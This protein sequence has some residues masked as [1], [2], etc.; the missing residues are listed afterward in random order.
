MNEYL[1]SALFGVEKANIERE[2]I[3]FLT[4]TISFLSSEFWNSHGYLPP[5]A[6]PQSLKR[7]HSE[8][9]RRHG[10]EDPESLIPIFGRSTRLAKSHFNIEYAAFTIAS[11]CSNP[12]QVLV[13]GGFQ[14]DIYTPLDRTGSACSHALLGEQ[15]GPATPEVFHLPDMDKD[16]RFARN[17]NLCS[18][19]GNRRLRFYISVPLCLPSG[20]GNGGEEMIAVGRFCLIS[21]H[22]RSWSEEESSL[23]K[24]LCSMTSEAIQKN[25][26]KARGLR[27]AVIQRSLTFL[28]RSVDEP[29][30]LDHS[31]C[32]GPSCNPDLSQGPGAQRFAVTSDGYHYCPRRVEVACDSIQVSDE[33]IARSEKFTLSA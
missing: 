24:D 4:E 14:D 18:L 25:R 13:F 19:D 23:L 11:N 22:T 26:E 17:P 9:L 15:V 33:E 30:L 29:A 2:V 32:I 20:N 3:Q 28:T 21:E 1:I 12:D 16:Y 5:P 8:V 7:K 27:M 31:Q 6:K 10:F